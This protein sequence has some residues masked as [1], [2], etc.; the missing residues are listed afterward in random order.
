MMTVSLLV[1]IVIVFPVSVGILLNQPAMT[2]A[3]G[4]QSD[5][6]AILASVYLAIGLV[7][8]IML[9][10][11]ASKNSDLIATMAIGLLS[12]QVVYKTITILTV[13]FA[14][15]VVVTNLCVIAVH[16][17]TLGLWAR[18]QMAMFSA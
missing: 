18:A 9:A 8:V 6:R 14:S 10:G 4:P 15:P 11:L 16:A 12:M 1:N 17:V 7:S 3:F 2:A 13:G 5:A